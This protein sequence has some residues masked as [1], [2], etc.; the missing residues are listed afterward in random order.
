MRSLLDIANIYDALFTKYTKR[1]KRYR[2]ELYA[3][4]GLHE[5][6]T[7]ACRHKEATAVAVRRDRLAAVTAKTENMTKSLYSKSMELRR[8][9]YSA[10]DPSNRR[11]DDRDT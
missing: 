11:T 3:L 7:R 9:H 1:L 10:D 5:A 4:E 6:A 8:R 2:T